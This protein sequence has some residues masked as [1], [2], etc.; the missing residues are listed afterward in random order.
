MDLSINVDYLKT[1]NICLAGKVPLVFSEKAFKNLS[2]WL[3]LWNRGDQMK[4]R[5]VS[6]VCIRKHTHAYIHTHRCDRELAL[7]QHFFRGM[8]YLCPCVE[9]LPDSCTFWIFRVCFEVFLFFFP[10]LHCISVAVPLSSLLVFILFVC[11]H[12][13]ICI[14]SCELWKLQIGGRELLPTIPPLETINVNILI[15]T[16]DSPFYENGVA[17][18]M[19]PGDVLFFPLD[20]MNIC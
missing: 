15:H 2:M 19:L 13:I 18:Y 8:R 14:C 6:K 12:G 16:S 9:W 1:L 17:V 7:M 11:L 3:C 20:I 10:C 4:L 5:W